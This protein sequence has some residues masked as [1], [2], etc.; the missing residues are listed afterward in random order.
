MIEANMR[1]MHIRDPETGKFGPLAAIKGDKG[2]SDGR[3][4]W[5]RFSANADGTDFTSTWTD[6]Q[7]YVGFA[8]SITEPLDKADYVWVDAAKIFGLFITTVTGTSN[9]I[10][11]GQAAVTNELRQR[12]G[13]INLVADRAA[14]ALLF[15]QGTLDPRDYISP[16]PPLNDQIAVINGKLDD[17]Y[18]RLAALE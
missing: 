1:L 9:N 13:I 5:I 15:I 10:V 6:G 7:K 17:I 3:N 8:S 14:D 18:E 11:M 2:D 16:P 12:D 4:A